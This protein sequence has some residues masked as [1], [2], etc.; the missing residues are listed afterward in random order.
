MEI[1]WGWRY[2]PGGG[3]HLFLV[4]V[5]GRWRYGGGG[6]IHPVGVE[7][8]WVVTCGERV[9]PQILSSVATKYKIQMRGNAKTQTQ[10]L[11]FGRTSRGNLDRLGSH[12][13]TWRIKK[14][15]DKKTLNLEKRRNPDERKE[16]KR[17]IGRKNIARIANVVQVTL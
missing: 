17:E 13:G 15:Y 11:S 2:P 9:G 7:R 10:A 3:G 5:G 1:C 6:D 4:V 16:R 12:G 8:L 14:I